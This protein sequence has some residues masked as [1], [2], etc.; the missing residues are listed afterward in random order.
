MKI[1]IVARDHETID[2]PQFLS[3]RR[4]LERDGVQTEII[5][6]P[7]QPGSYDFVLSVGGDGT[8][9]SAVGLV[10]DSGVPLVGIN[11]GHLGFL[12]TLGSEDTATLASDL[13]A[14][15]YTI[16]SHTL[17][18]CNVDAGAD[19]AVLNEVSLHRCLDGPLLRTRV[20]VDGRYVATY[21][22]DGLIVATPT[23]STAYSMSCGGPILTP[24][25]GCFVITPVGSHSLTLRPIIVPDTARITLQTSPEGQ[26]FYLSADSEHRLLNPGTT[27][28]LE[29]E[30]FS[31][32][33]VR[34]GSQHF[35]SAIHEKLSWDA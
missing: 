1:A 22:G 13:R 35:F 2:H 27:V 25:S 21:I 5:S 17:L 3:M 10:R 23:G 31:V 9:L 28:S 4:T 18:R 11:F 6:A 32:N 20:S 26:P 33:I 34:M 19:L 29:R 12:T 30:N 7:I 8:M 24:N 14:G 15:R 16:E